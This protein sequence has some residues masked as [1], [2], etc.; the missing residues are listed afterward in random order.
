[1]FALIVAIR[2]SR[3]PLRRAGSRRGLRGPADFLTGRRGLGVEQGIGLFGGIFLAATAVGIVGEGY[4]RGMAGAALDVA[5]GLGF[6]ILGL[7]LLRADAS[8][9]SCQPRRAAARASYGPVAG[10]DRDRAGGRRV[11]GSMLAGFVAA[12]ASRSGS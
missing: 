8:E 4:R 9:P 12:A 1:M 6:A 3:W 7:T 10:S 2:A 11:D 5:L